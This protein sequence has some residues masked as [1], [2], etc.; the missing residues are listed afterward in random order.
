[1]IEHCEVCEPIVVPNRTSCQNCSADYTLS[2]DHLK[3]Q[4]SS[5]ASTIIIVSAI[6]GGVVLIGAGTVL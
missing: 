6:V 2:D 3:C 1:M 5:N 4:S